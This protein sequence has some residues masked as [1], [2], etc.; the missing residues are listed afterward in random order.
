MKIFNV[1]EEINLKDFTDAVYPQGAFCLAALLRQKD[2][3]INGVRVNK[4]TPLKR[5]D[6]VVYYTTPRQ[7]G[8]PSHTVV[9][10][11]E[12]IY[13]A[14]K[15][16]GVSSEGLFSELTQKGEFYAVHRLDR[17]TQ[18]LIIY[19]KNKGAEEELLSAFRDRKITK[20]YIALCKNS[21]KNAG[22]VLTAYLVK[23]EKKNEVKI[24]PSPK[25]GAVKIITEYSFV[26]DRGDI[27]LIKIILHT[28]KTHQIR[29]HTA[30]IG[31]PVLGDEKYGDGLLNAKY[32]ARRQRLV[33]KYLN[34]NLDGNLSYLNGKVFESGFCL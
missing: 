3:K 34:F 12:N 28:G 26:E 21:F 4:N 23:D 15:P 1:T 18:G 25:D 20:T 16:D 29:A 9:Y 8:K 17:N 22:A 30:F 10:E 27:A 32:A 14:D 5:G 6:E 33:A 24:Y 11:D 2:V 31:C 7:E 19:A 13:I